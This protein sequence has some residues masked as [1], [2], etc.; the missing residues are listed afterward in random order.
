MLE[1]A[2]ACTVHRAEAFTCCYKLFRGAEYVIGNSLSV[3]TEWNSLWKRALGIIH[4][5]GELVARTPCVISQAQVIKA[6]LSRRLPLV[7]I[8]CGQERQGIL[9]NGIVRGTAS[10][11]FHQLE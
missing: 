4:S 1:R 6:T 8:A 9:R 11:A 3:S 5:V 7:G 10:R 2:D